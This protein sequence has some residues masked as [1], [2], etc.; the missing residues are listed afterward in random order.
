MSILKHLLSYLL[1]LTFISSS[2]YGDESASGK[3]VLIKGTVNVKQINKTK[4]EK[5]ALKD[6]VYEGDTIKTDANSYVQIQF[7]LE[8]IRIHENSLFEIKKLSYE[9]KEKSFMLI[10]KKKVTEKTEQFE[11]FMGKVYNKI[12]ELKRDEKSEIKTSAS[13]FGVY[14]TSYELIIG[15][16]KIELNVLDGE[17]KVSD[18]ARPDTYKFIKAGKKLITNITPLKSGE[19]YSP[20]EINPKNLEEI[21]NEIEDIIDN[22]SSIEEGTKETNHELDLGRIENE[23]KEES[24]VEKPNDE[25]SKPSSGTVRVKW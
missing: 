17:V 6:K 14:G 24:R 20:E 16:N 9:E 1:L 22:E 19:I 11:L 3:V 25:T 18:V 2:I 12:K 10:F 5:L 8:S 23:E 21:E 7:Q 15:E 4:Y 13:I